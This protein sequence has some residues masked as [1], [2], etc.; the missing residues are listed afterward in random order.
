MDTLKYR[1]KEG[2]FLFE[3][4]DKK[5]LIDIAVTKHRNLVDQYTSECED[6]KSSEILLTEQ[7]KKE[8]EEL[9]ARSNRKEVLEEKRKLLCY[10]A[11]KMLQQLFDILPTT[12]NTGAGQLKQMHKTLIQKGIELDKIKN[13]QKERALVD[14][15]KTVLETIPQNNEVSKIIALINKKFEGVVTSQTELQ[16]ISNIKEQKTVDETQ[17]KDISEKI[18]WLNERVNEHEQALSHWQG[19]L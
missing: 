1:N 16:T 10:Q 5:Q 19:E 12:E 17:I 3:I 4:P 8:K 14:E 9:A 11:E 6:M 13:L 15:I 2:L 7:I 18:L